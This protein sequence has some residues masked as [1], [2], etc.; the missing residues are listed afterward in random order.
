MQTRFSS[1]AKY[2]VSVHGIVPHQLM[3]WIIGITGGIIVANVENVNN[4]LFRQQLCPPD[5][6]FVLNMVAL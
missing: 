4:G 6:V 1:E 5:E 2:V 3:E